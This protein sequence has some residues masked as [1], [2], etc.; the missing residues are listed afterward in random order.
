MVITQLDML[1]FRYLFNLSQEGSQG[2]GGT[3]GLAFQVQ[4]IACRQEV[5][6][7]E[8][9]LGRVGR[10]RGEWKEPYYYFGTRHCLPMSNGGE[11]L[12]YVLF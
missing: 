6:P 10:M 1:A 7:E 2:S 8:W 9:T 5:T 12:C 4:I 3:T 11:R